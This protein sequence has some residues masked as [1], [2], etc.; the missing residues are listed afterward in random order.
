LL[1]HEVKVKALSNLH[2]KFYQIDT[3]VIY[4]GSAKFTHNGLSLIRQGNLEA[5]FQIPF[6]T[7][8]DAFIQKIIVGATDISVEVLNKM[9]YFI[10]SFDLLKNQD[11]PMVWANEIMLGTK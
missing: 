10:R 5:I 8:T 7:H 1:E 6:D 3:D 2:A 11:I 4:S 9:D